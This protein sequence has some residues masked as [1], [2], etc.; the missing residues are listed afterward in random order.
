MDQYGG[1]SGSLTAMRRIGAEGFRGI[2]FPNQVSLFRKK[3]KEMW[4]KRIKT[5]SLL[6]MVLCL[7]VCCDMQEE[8][9]R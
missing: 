4:M 7:P 6:A 8:S 1:V 9:Y 5:V 3:K 2:L